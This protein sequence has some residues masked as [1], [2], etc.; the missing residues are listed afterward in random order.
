MSDR[1]VGDTLRVHRFLADRG[2][3]VPLSTDCKSIGLERD[4]VLVAGVLYQ[5]FNGQNIW[6]HLAGSDGGRWMSRRFL[7]Y[8]F[9]YPFVE[10]G[11]QRLSAMVDASNAAS[12]RLVEHMGYRLEATL[13]GAAADGGDTLIYVMRRHECRF[14]GGVLVC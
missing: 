7:R 6:V 13:Q 12:R 3:R 8:G 11:V 1:L 5:G 4:G 9:A 10:L 14:L 2:V